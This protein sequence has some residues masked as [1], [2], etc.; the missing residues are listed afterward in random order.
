[1]S[2]N[3]FYRKL[4]NKYYCTILKCSDCGC[5]LEDSAFHFLTTHKVL[6]TIAKNKR[7]C[8]TASED[9]YC[10]SCV[11]KYCDNEYLRTA[12]EI[13][14]V[15][16]CFEPPR[17]AFPI[18]LRPNKDFVPFKGDL[19]GISSFSAAVSNKNLD[20]VAGSCKTFDKTRFANKESWKG[21]S[22]GCNPG[23]VEDKNN[24]L[25][26]DEAD[27]ILLD[28]KDSKQLISNDEKRLLE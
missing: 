12:I 8:W 25:S 16:P 15:I 11:Q 23:V 27:K 18:P 26:Y 7:W 2:S 17:D 24:L 4:N 19:S 21:A 22:I 3:L 10:S 5:D 20:S 13:K 14:N 28:M 1:M 9:V 6:K